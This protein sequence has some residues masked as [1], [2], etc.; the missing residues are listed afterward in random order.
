M[1]DRRVV[2]LLAGGVGRRAGAG[3]PKQLVTVGGH[4]LLEHTIAAVER[5]AALDEILV[6]MEAAH[7]DAARCIAARHSRVTAVIPGGAER[8][9]SSRL[10]VEHLAARLPGRTRV[11]LHDAARPYVTPAVLA[12]ADAAL[13]R[14][15]AAVTAVPSVDTVIEVEAAP[16]GG[17]SGAGPSAGEAGAGDG[18][19]IAAGT[20]DTD[21]APAGQEPGR[22][23]V[24]VP[25]RERMWLV[26]T[27]QAFR[28]DT[29]VAAH[30]IIARDVAF[31]P[32][33][34]G[35]VVRRALPDVP[36]AVVLGDPTNTKVTRPEDLRV[37]R[38]RL[39][40]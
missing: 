19:R 3:G 30:R 4:T 12:R 22:R 25:P 23:L 32:T 2:V 39:A 7:L 14:A 33:D 40:G 37:A 36:V 13:D 29:I 6:V 18:R 16:A 17:G 9:D 20:V 28:L 31:T 10:A 24:G 1:S 38:R 21:A 15:D 26:Q 35:S 34:D 8:A 27:P 5:W 11:L